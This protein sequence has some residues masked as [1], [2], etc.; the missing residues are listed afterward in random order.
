M[1]MLT[2][3]DSLSG[4][5]KQRGIAAIARG[6]AMNP[7]IMLFDEPTSARASALDCRN[8]VGDVLNVMNKE[9]LNWQSK[10]LYDHDYR[11]SRNGICHQVSQ[12][13]NL[14]CGR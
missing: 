4:G 2:S 9:I 5:Q 8:K 7:D 3:P 10:N 1:Q 11:Y 6:L 14:Y 13:S 12:P